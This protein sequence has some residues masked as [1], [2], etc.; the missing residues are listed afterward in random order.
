MISQ[1]LQYT[2]APYLLYIPY[3]ASLLLCYSLSRQGRLQ[4]NGG[5]GHAYVVK[6][7]SFSSAF[8]YFR[9]HHH[10]YIPIISPSCFPIIT[11]QFNLP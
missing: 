11:V 3:I 8:Q 10:T 2:Y 9:H 4:M 5:S 1:H 7:S 6:F